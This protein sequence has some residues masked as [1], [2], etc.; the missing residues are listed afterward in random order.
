MLPTLS[1]V[2]VLTY[3]ATFA[4]GLLVLPYTATRKIEAAKSVYLK[5]PKDSIRVVRQVC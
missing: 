4:N 3:P 1:M 5:I 2:A